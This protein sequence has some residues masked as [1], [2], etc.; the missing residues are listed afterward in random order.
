M[1]KFAVIVVVV[2]LVIIAVPLVKDNF[3]DSDT[4]AC[5]ME[6][7]ICL[8]GSAVG[9]TGPNCE[10]AECPAINAVST[11]TNNSGSGVSGIVLLGPTCPVE[12][13]PPEHACADKPYATAIT[14]YRA[15]SKTPFIIGNSDAEGK[16]TF[17]LPVGSYDLKA[18]GDTALPRCASVNVTVKDNNYATT[19]ISC[20]TGIR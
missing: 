19:T 2:V 10:F 4:K 20:D 6:A 15:N 5:T 16:F 1:R 14:V 3:K 17:N 12:K 13:V 9:R 7:K 18:I 11:T 8:D